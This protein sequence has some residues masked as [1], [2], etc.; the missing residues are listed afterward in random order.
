MIEALPRNWPILENFSTA[1]SSGTGGDSQQQGKRQFFD[2]VGRS[3]GVIGGGDQQMGRRYSRHIEVENTT[4][5][6]LVD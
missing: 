6:P 4:N 5:Y 1:G 3:K 2:Q